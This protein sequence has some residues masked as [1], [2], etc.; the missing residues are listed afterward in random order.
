MFEV[1]LGSVTL[2]ICIFI[3]FTM[4]IRTA[5]LGVMLKTESELQSENLNHIAAALVGVSELL[6]SADGLIEEV[7]QIPS[8]GEML[9]GMLS[10]ML[11]SKLAPSIQ[12][13]AEAAIPLI[14]DNVLSSM[15]GSQESNQDQTAQ[16]D[17]IQH[18]E[19]PARAGDGSDSEH[20]RD[21]TGV[22]ELL[23][24]RDADQS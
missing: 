17:G 12:P 3:L 19:H 22:L 11:I 16:V 10:Q 20:E 13:L 8:I 9:G 4:W 5:E 2:L 7:Q 23:D 18:Q 1:V 14:S 21:G 15:H 6:D 24:G